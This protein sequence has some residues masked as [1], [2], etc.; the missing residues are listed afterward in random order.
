MRVKARPPSTHALDRPHPS[1]N[2]LFDPHAIPTQ[3]IQSIQFTIKN[4]SR[5]TPTHPHLNAHNHA[6]PQSPNHTQ[7]HP[8]T[9]NNAP[10]PNRDTKR[11]SLV[12]MSIEGQ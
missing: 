7:T 2:Q 4:A 9:P 12:Y 8:R 3:S 1:M 11:T 6:P 10:S 5:Y